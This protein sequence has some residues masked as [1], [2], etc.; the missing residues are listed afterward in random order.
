ML[1]IEK[2]F[3]ATHGVDC[4][5]EEVC[6]ELSVD[7]IGEILPLDKSFDIILIRWLITAD[8]QP[9][10]I[11]NLHT[12]EKFSCPEKKSSLIV[13]L[14]LFSIAYDPA[15]VRFGGQLANEPHLVQVYL[16]RPKGLLVN[17]R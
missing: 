8:N 2:G 11:Q 13:A 5:D 6:K 10:Q 4:G 3:L 14:D 12:S 1:T 16:S 7:G 9:L 17:L 15:G